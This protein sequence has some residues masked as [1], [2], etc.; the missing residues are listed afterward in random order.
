MKAGFKIAAGGAA[1]LVALALLGAL[2]AGA[3]RR[4]LVTH[5][6]NNLRHL[7]GLAARN[8]ENLDKQKTGQLFWQEVRQAQY[9]STLGKWE[10][11]AAEPF[12]CP[13]LDHRI[14]ANP[15]DP[16]SIDYLGP[17]VVRKELKQTPKAEPIAADRPGNHG[18]GGLVLRLDT[19]V[20][21]LSP[22]VTPEDG[23]AWQAALGTLKD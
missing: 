7:G 13:L 12:T 16:K 8:W 19:S 18:S 5:C 23:P 22:L 1:V 15:E 2:Y 3:R 10:V 9:L 11:P 21:D 14:P 20:D 4:A 6:R 17:A